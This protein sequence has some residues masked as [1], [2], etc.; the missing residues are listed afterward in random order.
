[1]KNGLLRGR[2]VTQGSTRRIRRATTLASV[3]FSVALGRITASSLA[4][5]GM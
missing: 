2:R 3:A 4:A 1:M 5:S